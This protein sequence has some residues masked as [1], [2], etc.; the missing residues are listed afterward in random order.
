MK[1]F[2]VLKKLIQ[3]RP[4]AYLSSALFWAMVEMIPLLLGLLVKAIL[5]KLSGLSGLD[6]RFWWLVALMTG[7]YLG[8]IIFT[9]AGTGTYCYYS[10]SVCGLM[11]RNLLQA[12][13]R[14]P[15]AAAMPVSPAEAGNRFR[16]DILGVE[17]LGDWLEDVVAKL[18]CAMVAVGVLLTI[19]A[20]MT[21]LICFPLA[22]VLI[23]VQQLRKRVARYREASRKATGSAINLMGEIFRSVQAIQV[24]GAEECVI[25]HFRDISRAR[26]RAMVQDT[27]FIKTVD[28][29][30]SNIVH[31]GTGLIL[32]TAARSMRAGEF[33]VGD[34]ALFTMYWQFIADFTDNLGNMLASCQQARVSL[35]RLG[36]LTENIEEELVRHAPLPRGSNPPVAP[37]GMPEQPL[38]VLEIDGLSYRFPGSPNG[39]RDV[40]LTVR[41]GTF[42]VITGPVGSG[43]STLLRVFLGL[44][45]ADGGRILWNG[46]PVSDPGSF[47]VPPQAAYTGQMPRLFSD[48]IRNNILL[49][50]CDAAPDLTGAMHA[51]VL[52]QDLAGFADGLDT[53]AGP[54]GVRLSGGQIQR[55]AAARMFASRSQLYI[56]DDISSAL[57]VETESLL[58][59]RLFEK[60][61]TTCIAV[62]TR[63]DALRRADQIIVMHEGQIVAVGKLE[64]LLDRFPEMC[65]I[66]SG[67]SLPA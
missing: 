53:V 60:P 25:G 64:E 30:L 62:S 50:C 4:W 33:T 51:A 57:D 13:L 31:I 11:R 36:E 48:T 16:D 44:L 1:M 41:K 35:A 12:I 52:E 14:R 17:D 2:R 39:I 49:G 45:P 55:V 22:V 47:F 18:L 7:V 29:V 37:A 8:R 59:Q 58:W 15:G 6:Q 19:N 54:R 21:L 3:Y 40:S 20:R 66:C 46:L 38:A 43:K 10:F 32:L 42:T 63:P 27:L 34:F 26:H 67:D 9:Y 5:D 61:D 24:A 23:V 56:F 65:L 28:A